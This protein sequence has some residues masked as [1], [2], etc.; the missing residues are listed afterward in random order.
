MTCVVVDLAAARQKRAN[1]TR[2]RARKVV[3]V[4]FKDGKPA[5]APEDFATGFADTAVGQVRGR[6]VGL[7]VGPDGALYVSDDHGGFIYRITYT[8][9]EE[10]NPR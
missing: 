5:G 1:A 3:R 7:A 6:P 9:G 2:E 8:G 10:P 4:R